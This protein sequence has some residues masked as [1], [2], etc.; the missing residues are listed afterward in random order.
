MNRILAGGLEDSQDFC[1]Y[2]KVARSQASTENLMQN[3][4]KC[5]VP[6]TVSSFQA[7]LDDI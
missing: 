4:A 7:V 2:Q 6:N 5:A 3:V 1:S